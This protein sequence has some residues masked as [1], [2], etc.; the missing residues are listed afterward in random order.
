MIAAVD[1]VDGGTIRA[2]DLDVGA[3]RSRAARR[4][5]RDVVT[6]LA[7]RAAANLIPHLTVAEQLGPAGREHVEQLALAHR[8]DARAGELSGGEQARA[9]LAVGLSRE[10]PIVLVD[11]PTAELDDASAALAL[12][13]LLRASRSG[14]TL[15]VATHDPALIDAADATVTLA[16]RLDSAAPPPRRAQ[17]ARGDAVVALEAV[18]KSYDGV[19][20]VDDVTLAVAEGEVGVLLGRSGS[21]KST[22]LMIA[23]GWTRPDAGGVSVPGG[24]RT[25]AWSGTAYLAQRFALLPELSV[26]ENVALPLRLDGRDTSPAAR[27]LERLSLDGLRDRLPSEISIGQQQRTALAR[28]LVGRPRALLADEPTSHQDAGSAELVWA[29]LA[30]AAADGTACL[31]ATHDDASMMRGDRIWQIDDGRI[32]G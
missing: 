11:E 16:P 2:G 8:I 32:L 1:P 10:T 28:A 21:G 6:Y 24:T 31:V 14:R 30:E 29:A 15:V 20:V 7:Q 23:G 27:I 22:V 3:L 4:Y 25:P 18:T 5:R 26:A 9:A 17:P 13:L 12:E 19:R